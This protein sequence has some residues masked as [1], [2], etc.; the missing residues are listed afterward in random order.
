MCDLFMLTVCASI[1]QSSYLHAFD[2]ILA[3]ECL[4]QKKKKKKDK[5]Q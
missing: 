1:E 4:L 5:E 2:C 3:V